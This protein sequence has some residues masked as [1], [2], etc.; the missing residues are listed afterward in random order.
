MMLAENDLTQ[1]KELRTLDVE[2]YLIL[3]DLK[4][5]ERKQKAKEENGR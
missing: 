2:Q 4:V 3:L 1:L 5:K